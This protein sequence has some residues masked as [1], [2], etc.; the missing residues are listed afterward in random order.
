MVDLEREGDD[1]LVPILGMIVPKMGILTMRATMQIGESTNVL[2]DTRSNGLIDLAAMS[3]FDYLDNH[4]RIVD[5]IDNAI[6]TLPDS[7]ELLAG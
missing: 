7:I 1:R 2:S 3:H 4:F 5:R 6:R